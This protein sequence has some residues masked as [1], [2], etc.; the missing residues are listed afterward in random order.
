MAII[1]GCSG[2][3]GSSL[4]KTILNRHSQIFAG[5]E[6]C[7]FAYPSV[8]K[9]WELEKNKL[10]DDILT[11][12]WV[13]RKGVNLLQ[14]EYG[15]QEVE[16]KQLLQKSTSFQVFVTNFFQK[17]LTEKHKTVWIEKT[18]V[19]AY[20]F[21]AFLDNY[22][23]GK[24]IQ[25]IRNPY[26][27]IASLMARGMNAYYA[28]GYYV[29][30]TAIATS[31]YKHPSYYQLKYEDLVADPIATLLQLCEFLQLPFE[32]EIVTA[33]HEQ[34]SEPTTMKGWQHHETDAVVSSSIGRFQ[35]ME[36]REKKLVHAAIDSFSIAP[37]F[38]KR[39]KILFSNCRELC[40]HLGYPYATEIPSNYALVLRSY[41][42]KNKLSRW[43]FG[44]K[45]TWQKYPGKL[46]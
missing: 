44:G 14:T 32:E 35:Q 8:Y 12:G 10:L 25:I 13:I 38:L 21:Q 43:R 27:T 40:K 5:P 20:G 18:P 2:S 1:I 31:S 4:L 7:L 22:P 17:S 28:T 34:R 11:D 42:W 37:D 3:T 30:N 23:T 9:N 39:H 6:T 15:W 41:Q 45:R 26:D 29:Y 16:L 33:K 46:L 36:E 19:N 24:V